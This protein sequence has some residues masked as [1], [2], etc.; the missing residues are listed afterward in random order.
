MVPDYHDEEFYVDELA[1]ADRGLITASG[2]GAV[3]FTREILRELKIYDEANLRAW[4]DMFKHGIPPE[5][6]FDEQGIAAE[7][8]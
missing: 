5:G 3:E 8:Q 4:F 2:L 7:A 1:V 6:E